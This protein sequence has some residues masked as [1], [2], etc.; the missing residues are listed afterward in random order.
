VPKKKHALAVAFAA[1]TKKNVTE[2][3]LPCSVYNQWLEIEVI[4]LYKANGITRQ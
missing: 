2:I 1:V 3:P 4:F